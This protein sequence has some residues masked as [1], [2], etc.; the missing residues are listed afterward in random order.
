[1]NSIRF[2][3]IV[4]LVPFA[5]LAMEKEVK[6]KLYAT[7]FE[8]LGVAYTQDLICRVKREKIAQ[9]SKYKESDS[10]IAIAKKYKPLVAQ[11]HEAKVCLKYIN[12]KI[13]YG[14]FAEEDISANEMVGEYTGE[15]LS[16]KKV[17]ALPS[18]AQADCV[19]YVGAFY[20]KDA[21]RDHLFVDA[22]KFG[23]FTRFINHSGNPNVDNFSV[24]GE[25]GL[26]HI[27]VFTIKPIKKDEQLLIDYGQGYWL[28]RGI[29]PEFLKS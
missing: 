24:L 15:L 13:G 27:P 12:D 10:E 20:Q 21:I 18:L 8:K 6:K 2:L 22:K 4:L 14:V 17:D 9:E 19:M 16:R 25:D 1:M 26:W 3:S 5:S 29:V 7:D 28:H 23:N 11:K